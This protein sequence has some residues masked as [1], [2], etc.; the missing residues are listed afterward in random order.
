[1]GRTPLPVN[2]NTSA[3]WNEVYAGEVRNGFVRRHE[4]VWSRAV[5]PLIPVEGMFLDVGCGTGEFLAWLAPQR[6]KL[7]IRGVDH[8]AYAV[9]HFTENTYPVRPLPNGPNLAPIARQS[10]AYEIDYLD[11]VLDCVYSGHLLEHLDDPVAALREQYRIL[12]WQGRVIVHFPYEDKPYV[13]HLAI[14]DFDLVEA[15]LSEAGF[16]LESRSEVIAGEP[17]N[18]AVVSAIKG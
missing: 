4:D 12:Q 17:T 8:S 11:N 9:R 7:T 10:S 2:I 16:A 18:D 15:W 14:L 6:P 1:M 3:Y 13:E 5:L